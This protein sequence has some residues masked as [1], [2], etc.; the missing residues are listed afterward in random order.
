MALSSR[1]EASSY[2]RA[3]TKTGH[4]KVATGSGVVAYPEQL[5]LPS[6]VLHWLVPRQFITPRYG[7]MILGA[8][9][10]AR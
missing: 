8:G 7:V 2:K 9:S 10:F 6:R 4:G 1:A 3:P 5:A